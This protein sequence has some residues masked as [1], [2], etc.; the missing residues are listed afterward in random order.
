MR[1]AFSSRFQRHTAPVVLAAKTAIAA[2][3]HGTDASLAVC[4]SCATSMR[5]NRTKRRMMLTESLIASRTKRRAADDAGWSWD[6]RR[7]GT[8]TVLSFRAKIIGTVLI[9]MIA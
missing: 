1:W 5:V 7:K 3:S 6:I 2:S 4:H 9:L 8:D